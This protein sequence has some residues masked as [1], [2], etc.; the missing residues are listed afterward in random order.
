M[1]SSA[2][3]AA[4]QRLKAATA[5][6]AMAAS[7][8]S[9]TP[10]AAAAPAV[11]RGEEGGSATAADL[12]ADEPGAA[13]I[14]APAAAGNPGEAVKVREARV[15]LIL[16]QRLRQC[17]GAQ[18]TSSGSAEK[19]AVPSWVFD[20]GLKARPTVSLAAPAGGADVRG[21][22]GKRRGE[23]GGVG[24]D[25]AVPAGARGGEERE[26]G[27]VEVE[28]EEE[29]RGREEGNA[30]RELADVARGEAAAAAAATAG[31]ERA[32]AAAAALRATQAAASGAVGDET[33]VKVREVVDFAGE[34]V[35]VV[36]V[37]D[38]R[39]KEAAAAKRKADMQASTSK[40]LDAILAQMEKKKKLNIL[41]KSRQDWSEYKEG[42]GVAVELEEYRR[43]GATYTEKKA[44][45]GQADLRE[46]ERERDAKLAA[47]ARRPRPTAGD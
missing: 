10:A 25:G 19:K 30:A 2:V 21:E 15:D 5:P 34:A 17:G 39:S 7:R 44:F 31:V 6:A 14:A 1:S 22:G 33:K 29:G 11:P 47:L 35:E 43:S 20:L 18:Q 36:R 8:R 3:D 28:G 42:T 13:D 38:P 27:K 4:W 32:A 26:G 37:L 23:E 45:L 9:A 12:N 16:T 24:A 46:Y 40:G 41:D